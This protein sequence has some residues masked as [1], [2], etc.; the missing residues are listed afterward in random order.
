MNDYRGGGH[1]SGRLT[2]GWGWR[3][4]PSA[5]RSCSAG[6]WSQRAHRAHRQYEG[7]ELTMSMRKEILDARAAGDSVGGV[8]EVTCTGV[9]PAS[10]A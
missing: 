4:V 10:A 9:P 7:E 3:R 2:A 6:A 8:I 1:F 5:A